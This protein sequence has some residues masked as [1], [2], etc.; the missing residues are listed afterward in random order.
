[1]SFS[2]HVDSKGIMEFLTYLNPRNIVL[3]HGDNEKMRDFKHKVNETLKIPCFN[4]E[5]HS[6]LE[7][8]VVRKIPIKVSMNLLNYFYNSSI[9]SIPN[10]ILYDYFKENTTIKILT[11]SEFVYNH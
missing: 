8:D 7:I 3:V 2:A 10:V 4:P 6:I 9:F 1:M 5:N 11:S